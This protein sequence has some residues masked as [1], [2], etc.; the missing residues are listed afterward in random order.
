MYKITGF[1]TKIWNI[2]VIK[3][4]FNRVYFVNTSGKSLLLQ[5]FVLPH[6]GFLKQPSIY[7]NLNLVTSI[8]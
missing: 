6:A 7:H 1:V 4:I 5:K 3:V 2:I 8:V